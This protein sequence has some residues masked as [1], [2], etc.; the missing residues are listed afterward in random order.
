M[1]DESLVKV[2]VSGGLCRLSVRQDRAVHQRNR[3]TQD[4]VVGNTRSEGQKWPVDKL[5]PATNILNNN[6]ILNNILT[7]E[8]GLFC[9]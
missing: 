8:P 6:N 4:H 9:K 7:K 5:H 2:H 3:N 1:L